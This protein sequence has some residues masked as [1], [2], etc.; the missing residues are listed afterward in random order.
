[1][2]AIGSSERVDPNAVGWAVERLF[3]AGIKVHLFGTTSYKYLMDSPVYSCD[4]SNWTQMAARDQLLYWNPHNTTEDKKDTIYV[5]RIVRTKS[6]NLKKFTTY[7]H[8]QELEDY[9]DKEFGFTYADMLGYDG[10][11]N[12]QLVNIHFLEELQRR[13]TE[14]HLQHGWPY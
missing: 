12:R 2:V 1:M 4:S 13:I 5:E 9:L 11:F 3:D 7:E 14:N 10:L 8:R 6:E